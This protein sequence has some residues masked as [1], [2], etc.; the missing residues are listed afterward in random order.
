M[1]LSLNKDFNP[2]VSIL[3]ENVTYSLGKVGL[4]GA[5]IMFIAIILHM[6]AEYI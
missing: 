2:P 5:S 3:M 4:I 1:Q 6:L